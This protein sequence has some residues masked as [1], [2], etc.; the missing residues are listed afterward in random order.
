M[1]VG[2]GFG[3][4]SHFWLCRELQWSWVVGRLEVWIF[5]E[6]RGLGGRDKLTEFSLAVVKIFL[7]MKMI[8]IIFIIHPF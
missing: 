6:D 8:L 1:S 3:F 2:G 7:I 4:G 5:F